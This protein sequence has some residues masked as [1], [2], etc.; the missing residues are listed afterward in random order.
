MAFVLIAWLALTASAQRASHSGQVTFGK[1]PVPGATVTAVGGGKEIVTTSETDGSYR[2]S[3]LPDGPWTIRIEMAGFAAVSREVTLPSSDPVVFELTLLPFDEIARTAVRAQGSAA[4]GAPAA[5]QFPRAEVSAA[6][7]PPPDRPAQAAPPSDPFGNS[8]MSAADGLLINGSVN[9]GAASP[10]SQSAAF[11]NNRRGPQSLYNWGLGGQ[12]GNSALDARPYSFGSRPAPKPAYTNVQFMG[13]FGG[14]VRIPG[15]LRNGPVVYV[16]YQRL[17]DHNAAT[18]SAIMPTLAER[19]GDFSGSSIALID[20]GTGQPFEG[21]LIPESRISDQARSLLQYYPVPNLPLADGYN[22]QTPVVTQTNQDSLQTR[23]TQ[24][25][26]PRDQLSA[27]VSYQRT[28][29]EAANVFGFVDSTR[30]ANLDISANWSHRFS[31]LVNMRLRYQHTRLSNDVVPYFSGRTNVS[32]E[33]GITGN[34]Q[35]PENWGPPALIFSSGIAGLGHPQFTASGDDAH[36]GGADI[37]WGKGRHYL[38][39]GGGARQR[40]IDAF[41][42]QDARG[43]FTM[44]GS[45]TGSDVADFLLGTPH[46]SSIAFGNPD[47]LLRGWMLDSYV[48]DDWRLSPTLTLNLGVRWEYESPLSEQFGRLANLD[49]TTGFAGA[50]PVLASDPVGPLTGTEYPSSLVRADWRGI[51][52]RLGM[53]WRP[54]AGSSLVVRAGYGVYR[55][56]NVYQSIAMGMAQQPPLSKTVNAESTPEMPLTLANGFVPSD[57]TTPNTFAVDPDLR[58]GLAQN[59]QVS[60]QRDLPASLTAIATYLGAAGNHL[61]QQV[62]PNTYPAGGINPC[63]ACPFGFVHLSSQGSSTRHAAQF[64][65]RRRLRSGLTATAQYTLARATDDA[66]ALAGASM[67]G[68]TIAQDWLDPGAEYGRSSFDQRHVMTAQVQYTTGVGVAGGALLGG[69]KAAAFKGWT[70]S[71]TLNAGSGLPLTATYLTTVPGTAITGTMRADLT[72][73]PEDDVPDGF[74]LNPAA[75]TLP[76]AGAWGSAAR[77]S[78]AGPMQFNLDAGVARTFFVGDRLNLDLRVD[79]ANVLN[80]VTFAGVNT[81]V[82]SPQ[83]GLANRANTMR[84]LQVTMRLRY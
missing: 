12:F 54:I 23:A 62:L 35:Q 79:A 45:A 74:Y 70:L 68:S 2:F 22:F 38:T 76:A 30:I 21:N 72:G 82:G 13:T 46:S 53:A 4:T 27:A 56:T 47:K 51:Q 9:N 78:I 16:G 18:Q 73:A 63:P 11:G 65:I 55:N 61:L 24:R 15:L 83:F 58:V 8:A 28:T 31:P 3:D 80:R 50:A 84:R 52:P 41:G 57:T 77:H 1:L 71:S 67:I 17:A 7:T 60:A 6:Q 64:Q 25:L 59:W 14:P 32:G 26:T 10:F 39:F 5:G 44:T 37:A 66:A 33:A 49:I 42:Q 40:H 69:W 75:Y 36:G 19:R 29:T 34:D 48:N 43:V 20:P 81:I